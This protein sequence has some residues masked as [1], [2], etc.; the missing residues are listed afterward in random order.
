MPSSAPDASLRLAAI[1][2]SSDDAIVSKD[3]NGIITSWNRAA[4]SLFGFQAAEAV[5]QPI[6]IV[7]PED[8]LAE[9]DHVLGRIRRGWRVDHFETTRRR[10]D[11]SAVQV[12]LTVSPIRDATGTIVGASQIVRDI[13]NRKRVESELH[14]LRERL[15]SLAAA[16]ASILGSPDTDDVLASSVA[17]AREVFDADGYAVWRCIGPGVWKIVRSVG[18]SETFAE[19]HVVSETPTPALEALDAGEPIVFED[20]STASS[21]AASRAAYE[22]EGIASMIV[23]PLH[24]RGKAS[25]TIVFYTKRPRHFREVDVQVGRALANIAAAALSTAEVYSEQRAAREAADHARQQAAFLATASTML[26]ASLDYEKTLAAVA[27]LAVPTMADW[28]AVDIV[29]ERGA[30]RRL[31]VA[32][33]D[34]A[35]LEFARSLQERYPAD[36]QTPGGIHEVIRTGRPAFMPNIPEELLNAAARDDEHRRLIQ[37][38]KLTSYICVP[39]AAQGRVFGALTFV[40][41]ESGRHYAEDDLRFASEIAVRASLAVEN[42]RL[43][44][45]AR[46]SN[47]MKDEFLATLSHELRTPLNAV[48]GYTRLLQSGTIPLEQATPALAVIE[49]NGT[50]LKR[51]IEDVLDVSRIVAGKLRLNVQPVDLAEILQESRATIM[52][53]AEAKGIRVEAIIDPLGMP[54]SGDPDRLR[55]VFWNLLSNAIKFTP[56]GG[57]MQL[58]LSRVDSHVEIAV[59]D[60]GSGIAAETLPFVFDR[61]LQADASFSREHG[62]LGLGLSI[63]KQLTELHGG[64]L[65]AASDGVGKGATFTMTLP[66]MIVHPRVSDD[67]QHA[68]PQVEHQ[69]SALEPAPRLDGLRILAVDDEA[70]SLHL[71]RSILESAGATVAISS[72]ARAA[73]ETVRS[74]TPDVMI[75]DIG[76]PGMDGLQFIRAIREMDAPLNGIPAAALTA[77]ARSQDRI[78][79]FASGFQM[80]LVKPVEPLELIVAV[81]TLARRRPSP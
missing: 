53:A 37:A 69:M 18:V 11:G 40:S 9:E 2:E 62:G 46:D 25:G 79:S 39:L 36:P 54:V 4:E 26:S 41:A 63:A 67:R 70:D 3:L 77:Y 80:H 44:A 47:R 33:V 60:T 49:R 16:S 74:E 35:K 59:S 50:A 19:R 81:S 6:T 27:R 61:F 31:A 29:G 10:K 52:P 75:A 58:R 7:I 76:M 32:H 68:Q 28:C 42:A 20:V 34:P 56:R 65:V 13:S 38:L 57:R 24:I 66:L 14:E 55:Q 1:I 45:Q 12:S 73:L 43:Y 51:I 71:L 48:L 64:S 23:F 8:R 30:L 78:A 17:L 15:L 21:L 22:A 72:S 5:G